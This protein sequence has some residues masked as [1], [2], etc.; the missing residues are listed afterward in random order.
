MSSLALQH[1]VA[2]TFV[3]TLAVVLVSLVRTPLRGALGARAAYW[4]WLTVPA[5]AAA[6]LL[7]GSGAASPAAGEP[8]PPGLLGWLWARVELALGAAHVPTPWAADA[9]AV[10]AAGAIVVLAV[11]I[12]R[13]RTFVRSLGN[14]AAQADG[15]WRS[16]TVAEPM[17]VGVLRPR[18]LVPV[19]FERR[20]SAQEREFVMAHERAH[21]RRGDTLVNALGA[22]S[23]C[24]FWFN[25]AMYWAM[26]LLRFDQDLACDAWVLAAAGRAHRRLYAGAL[27]KAQLSGEAALPVPIACHWRSVHPLKRRIAALRRPGAGPLRH[28]AGIVLVSALAA[29]MS[30]AAHAVQPALQVA[31]PVAPH[32]AASA[33]PTPV[34]HSSGRVCPR[35]RHHARERR[36]GQSRG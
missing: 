36:H 33:T 6:V 9:L 26:C 32:S 29:S 20:Y 21:L 3:T 11:T 15:T 22:A 25:P 7:P 13:Q 18:V 5:S 14:L 1:L 23:L 31:Q 24:A 19:D 17:L 28:R 2:V 10:W 35:S 27:L 16:D 34:G 4:V 12:L 8:I 30:L